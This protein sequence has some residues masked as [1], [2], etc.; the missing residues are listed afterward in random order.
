[1][2]E[3]LN[4]EAPKAEEKKIDVDGLI[5]ELER[6]GVKDA[7]ELSGKLRASQETGRLAQLLGDERKAR[8]DLEARL[9]QLEQKPAPKHDFMDDYSENK[10]IDIEA[11]LER[12]INR[13]LTKKEEQQRKI[14]EENLRKWN[15]IVSDDEYG[16]VKEIWEEKL[17]DPNLVMKIQN[18]M[19][20]PIQEYNKTVRG[21]Y[22]TL[23]QKSHETI[24][25]MRGGKV[26]PPHVETGERSANIVSTTPSGSEAER[27]IKEM[28]AKTD[29]GHLLSQEEELEMMDLLFGSTKPL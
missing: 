12:T 13:V 9:N 11:A 8:A 3:P 23:L 29:K 10:P 25:T 22:K 28:K 1:M 24:T 26:A 14:Q 7:A 15:A 27:K 5:S 20:D 18:G 17:K 16:V 2:T 21:Y 4:V 19:V 6:A